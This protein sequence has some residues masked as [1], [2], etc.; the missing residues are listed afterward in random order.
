MRSIGVDANRTI[1]KVGSNLVQINVCMAKA[2]LVSIP[3]GQQTLTFGP[4]QI[5]VFCK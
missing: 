4:L 1:V 3:T 2:A 5:M